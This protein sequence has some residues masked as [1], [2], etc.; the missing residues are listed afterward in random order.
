MRTRVTDTTV[1]RKS[2]QVKRYSRRTVAKSLEYAS[3]MEACA[4]Y[5]AVQRPRVSSAEEAATLLRPLAKA[6]TENL[7]E[8][9]FVICLS[10]NNRVLEIPTECMRGL[11]AS[12][13][14][15]PREIFRPAICAGAFMIIL[16]HNH[17]SGDLRVSAEDIDITRSLL[18]A[19]KTLGIPIQ[20]HLIL[21]MAGGLPAYLSFRAEKLFPGR[22]FGS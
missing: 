20:D 15:H 2:V 8:S 18:A 3:A 21:G 12:V 7:Q 17:P 5:I 19:S 16:A 11:A 13:P 9:F 4:A 6:A 1:G 10:I 22:W 14:V